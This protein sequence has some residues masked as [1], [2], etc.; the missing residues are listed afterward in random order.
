M[1]SVI[2]GVSPIIRSDG[3]P[4]RDYV[5]VQDAVAGYLRLAAALDDPNLKGEA[6][7]FGMDQPKSALEI[8][9]TIIAISDSPHIEPTI[10]NEAPLVQQNAALAAVSRQRLVMGCHQQGRAQP[11]TEPV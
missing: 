5:Y 1:R 11:R 2:Y 4:V 3:S 7:N 10:L 9:Q 8:V 6:F